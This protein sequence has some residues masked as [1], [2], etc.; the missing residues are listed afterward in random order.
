MQS[1]AQVSNA[2][3]AYTAAQVRAQLLGPNAQHYWRLRHLGPD[4]HPIND[5]AMY[6]DRANN[7]QVE[8]DTNRAVKRTLDVT[9]LGGHGV[10]SFPTD[11]LQPW[12]WLQMPAGDAVGWPLG[13]FLA[14]PPKMVDT[15]AE[16][17]YQFQRLP[18]ASQLLADS[19]F[20]A[21][22]GVPAGA[23]YLAAINAIVAGYGGAFPI[24]TLIPDPGKALPAALGW[25]MGKSR[26]EAINDLLQAV[27][28]F[29]AWFDEWGRLRSSPIPNWNYLLPTITF[30][31]TSGQAI[32]WPGVE[33]EPDATSAFNICVVKVEDPRRAN[34]YA[35]YTSTSPLSP[36]S[37]TRWHAKAKYINDSKI[38]DYP[39]AYA[40]AQAEVQTAARLVSQVRVSSFPWPLSQDNDVYGVLYSN[41]ERGTVAYTA[42]E[43]LWRMTLVGVGETYHELKRIYIS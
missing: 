7:P 15:A 4:G 18:D 12:Y 27:N 28:Y 34:F 5:L 6:V 37:I 2:G 3:T 38:V 16:T 29:P 21:S 23:S 26:L 35:T 41:P 33:E 22:Y 14:Y 43:T 17:L 8:H 11:L 30:D 40:R 1:L 42:L 13:V 24:K 25:E 19:T 31:G 9:L 39:T 20:L 36:T 32:V 10:S